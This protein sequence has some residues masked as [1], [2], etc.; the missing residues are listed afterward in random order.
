MKKYR[1]WVRRSESFLE[2]HEPD[3][4]PDHE[5]FAM[6]YQVLSDTDRGV[7]FLARFGDV[8]TLEPT[9]TVFGVEM[10]AVEIEVAS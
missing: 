2:A 9:V 8:M 6:G 5:I 1:V 7:T 10:I 3:R 4:K